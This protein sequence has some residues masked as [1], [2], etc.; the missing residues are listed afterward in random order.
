VTRPVRIGCASGFWG[1][2]AIAVPQLV[3]RGELHYLVS[4]YLAELTLSIMAAAR[5]KSAEAGHARDWVAALRPALPAIAARGIKVVSNAGGL[6]P[7][8]CREALRRAGREAGVELRIAVVTGDDLLPRRAALAEAGVREL[9]TGAPLPASATSVNAYL[10]AGGIAAALRAGADVVITGRVV[11]S[12]LVLGP[13]LHEHGW[14]LDDWDRLAQG[15]LAGHVIECGAQ[16]TGGNFTDWRRVPDLEHIGFPI[17]EV[18]EDGSFVVTKPP[19]TGGLVTR[20]TVGEQIVYEIGDPRAYLLPDVVCDFTGVRLE[21]IGP[22]AVRVTGAR[23]R[24]PPRDYKVAATWSDGFRCAGMVAM[25]GADAGAKARRVGEAILARAAELNARDGLGPFR[26]TLVEV[27]GAEAMY[28]ARGRDP[29]SREAVL[30]VAAAH[31]RKEALER[32][33]SEIA[34]FFTGGPPGMTT[35]F[36]GRPAVTPL[37][38]LFSCLVPKGEVEVRVEVEGESLVV[39]VP[40]GARAARP[41]AGA[42]VGTE[43]AAPLPECTETVPLVALAWARSGDKGDHANV[44]VLARRPEYLPFL[45]AALTPGAVAEHLAHALAP[46]R[47][48][49]RRWDLPGLDGMNFLLEHAL[50]GGGMASL[51]ADPQGKGFAQ[52]LLDVPIPVTAEIARRAREEGARCR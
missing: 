19:G 37:L 26:E 23:G 39:D 50:G 2:S 17:A 29:A 43:G 35:L 52:Q 1:D 44:G 7:Q 36:G 31:D 32:L 48:R 47:G 40:E 9:S 16:C 18:A 14:A 27:L 30:R 33:A 3:E 15:S 41:S 34:P 20:G 21:E 25:V 51:R 49:V 45:R 22:D 6:N 24:P 5:L 11:D 13:L 38:R 8:A 10:G 4:D 28:G 42:G 12:A 46:G